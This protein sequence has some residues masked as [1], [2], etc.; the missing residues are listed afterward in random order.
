M[1]I[2]AFPAFKNKDKNPHQYLLYTAIIAE[3]NVVQEFSTANILKNR[4]DIVHVHWPESNKLRKGFSRAVGY[5]AVFN[6]LIRLSK[7]KGSKIVWTVHNLASHEKKMPGLEAFHFKLFTK[8]LDGI[9]V[10]NSKTS[11]KAVEKYPALKNT[12]RALIPRGHYKTSYE[13]TMSF[14]DARQKLNLNEEAKVF[15]FLGQIRS[16]KGIE[17]FLKVFEQTTDEQYRFII[18]GSVGKANESYGEYLHGLV[19]DKRVQLHIRFI[20]DDELQVYFNAADLVVLPYKDILNSGSLLLAL[21]FN[22]PVIVPAHE[23]IQEIVT[24]YGSDWLFSYPDLSASFIEDAMA[25]ALLKRGKTLD[26]SNRDW[27][28]V[29]LKTLSFYKLLIS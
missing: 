13:N 3:G 10:M 11:D 22:K 17:E 9:I 18:A 4:Y 23:S 21:S 5:V 1:K 16:Y 15:L 7:M 25:K 29:A 12:R 14:Y 20:P 19:K 24:E 2:A 27:K 28:N 6:F 26:M 8:M